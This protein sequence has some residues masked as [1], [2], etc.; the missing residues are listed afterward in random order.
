MTMESI[1][2][3][4]PRIVPAMILCFAGCVLVVHFCSRAY[5]VVQ[6]YQQE[7][8]IPTLGESV[9]LAS[10]VAADLLCF[11]GALCAIKGRWV[12]MLVLAASIGLAFRGGTAAFEL[13]A[14][15]LAWL[16]G[17]PCFAFAIG[18]AIGAIGARMQWPE[19]VAPLVAGAICFLGPLLF[20]FVAESVDSFYRRG[21][22]LENALKSGAGAIFLFSFFFAGRG[23]IPGL[24]GALVARWALSGVPSRQDDVRPES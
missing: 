3:F 11:V 2:R 15:E 9:G 14:N 7:A 10:F 5:S 21:N 6:A 12:A 20:F 17:F 1:P 16:V 22:S 23:P 4:R 24:V 8:R 18:F 13:S 19:G